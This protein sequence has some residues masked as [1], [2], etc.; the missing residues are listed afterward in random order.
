MHSGN[1]AFNFYKLKNTQ[2]V[3]LF[4]CLFVAHDSEDYLVYLEFLSSGTWCRIAGQVV[5]D[6]SEDTT[7]ISK[8]N[9]YFK[10]RLMLNMKATG[11][12]ETSVITHRRIT[13]IA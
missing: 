1:C 10:E 6:F 12:I 13:V 9:L 3:C 5:Q 2:T 4:V 11:F 7:F 8:I